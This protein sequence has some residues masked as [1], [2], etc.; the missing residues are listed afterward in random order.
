MNS[1]DQNI[2]PDD[3]DDLIAQ[4]EADWPSEPSQ[5]ATIIA[6][7]RIRR[8]LREYSRALIPVRDELRDLDPR[9]D[10][11]LSPLACQ[12]LAAVTAGL[13]FPPEDP[14][15]SAYRR[16]LQQA[17][18]RNLDQYAIDAFEEVSA[19]ID[20]IEK[21]RASLHLLDEFDLRLPET[22]ANLPQAMLAR[23]INA[24]A[25]AVFGSAVVRS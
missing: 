7:P 4:S 2:P 9:S 15:H 6:I 23:S 3:F 10:R 19:L 21:A 16:R 12:V 18:A 24:H 25:F 22:W 5:P 11:E 17:E 8:L 13:R 1:D 20:I 14:H